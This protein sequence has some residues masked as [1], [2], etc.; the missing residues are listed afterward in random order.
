MNENQFENDG[1]FETEEPKQTVSSGKQKETCPIPNFF[2]TGFKLSNLPTSISF[3]VI[4]LT[5][6][7]KFLS[8]VSF[9]VGAFV[10]FS[11]FFF[12]SYLAMISAL[13]IE[14]SFAFKRKE[15]KFNL[16]FFMILLAFFLLVI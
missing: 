1:V 9:S 10:T 6:F 14:V 16:N 5:L 4:F 3:C 2:K 8:M 13:L 11:I 15:F 12:I 7:V